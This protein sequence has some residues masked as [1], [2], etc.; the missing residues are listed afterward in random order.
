MRISS[1]KKYRYKTKNL[2]D[3][4]ICEVKQLKFDIMLNFISKILVINSYSEH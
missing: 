1:A 2:T 4:N 3:T